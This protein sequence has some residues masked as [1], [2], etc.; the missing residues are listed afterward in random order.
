MPLPMTASQ[1]LDREFLEIRAKILE[2][3]ASFD[4]LER[5]EGSVLDDP[6]LLRL[7][8]ALLLL[9]PNQE[10]RAEHVQLLFSRPYAEQWRE[11]FELP[12][13]T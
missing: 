11:D 9:G 8:E 7:R 10:N 6:R 4:R 3:A 12:A 2:L 13:S 5:G 1:V